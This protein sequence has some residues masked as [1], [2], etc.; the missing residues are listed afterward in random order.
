MSLTIVT[1]PASLA[2]LLLDSVVTH[3]GAEQDLAASPAEPL[4]APY[5]LALTEA[6]VALLDGPAGKLGRCLLS[7]T[8]RLSIDH[9][10][11]PIIGL[12]L[13]PLQS[14]QSV[15]YT[16]DN[17]ALLT[18]DAA[19]YRVTGTGSW[20]TEIAPAYGTAWPSVRWQREAILVEFVAGYG[21][22][23]EDVPPPILQAIRL[24]VAHWWQNREAV[25]VGNIT[26]EI[27]LGVR[28]LLNPYRV[29]RGCNA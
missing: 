3:I 6:A 1:A 15:K 12:T 28:S 17:G 2:A 11:P 25:N 9:H 27:P 13:P 5:I 18:L 14:V 24:L 20:L 29:F 19:A 16:D 8:W 26:S 23:A 7:Q 4:D 10:F 21:D 22:G